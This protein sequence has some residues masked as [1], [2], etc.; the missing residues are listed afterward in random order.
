MNER[1]N[2][3]EVRKGLFRQQASARRSMG[4]PEPD[5]TAE[6]LERLDESLTRDKDKDI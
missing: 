3:R 5:L 1:N 2:D 4:V 6:E